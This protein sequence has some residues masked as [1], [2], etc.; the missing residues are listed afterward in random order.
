VK[1]IALARPLLDTRDLQVVLCMAAT[2]STAKAAPMLHLTQSAVS[3]ALLLA[4]EKLGV[5]LF[6]RGARGLTP[7]SAGERLI[8][9][10]GPLLAQLADL[11]RQ[12][13]A[14]DT[15]PTKVRLVCECY[16]AYR[17]LPSALQRMQKRLPGLEVT[18][19]VD[20][21]TAPV[22]ALMAGEIDVA[23]LTTAPVRGPLAE[24]PL[25][26]D[27]IV[28]LVA[29]SHPLAAR[30]SI[31][32]ADLE[33]TLVITSNTPPAE[34]RWFAREVFGK[35]KPKLSFLRLPLTEAI[36]DAARA[37]MGVAVLSEWMAGPY[38]ADGDL[39][40]KRLAS[41]PLRRPWRLAFRKEAA[42]V[43]HQLISVLEGAAPRAHI[44]RGRT[45]ARAMS[46]ATTA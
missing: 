29:P 33:K 42:S 11:E 14:P 46:V 8:S 1:R 9:G 45:S 10:A 20:H 41:G 44:P 5:R 26:S 4:E 17:W 6:E 13:T 18:L 2:G 25:F 16:T 31:T 12:V 28:F 34:A 36:M 24:M 7:T 38:L 37:G 35:R 39:V 22:P 19:A 43:A 32:A 15:A 23:L 3:R 40:A 30:A 21:T 27:E